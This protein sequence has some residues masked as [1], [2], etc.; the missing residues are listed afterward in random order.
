MF[1]PVGSL[2]PGVY[3]R[4]RVFAAAAIAAVL[5]VVMTVIAVVDPGRGSVANSAA[6]HSV[7]STGAPQTH[8]SSA[9]TGSPTGSS[10]ASP[11]TTTSTA[12]I[13]SGASPT[14]IPPGCV[15][16]QLTITAAT[17]APT[18]QV[19]KEPTLILEVTN[20]GPAQCTQDLADSQI[21][22]RVYNGAARVWGS[23]DCKIEPGTDVKTL[24]VATTV[25][26]QVVWSG[27]SSQPKCAG[28][29]QR[30]GAGT[31]TVYA[32]LSGV[33]GVPAKFTMTGA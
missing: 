12:V 31:Y 9:P 23:H 25:G 29:R 27:L 3:W 20:N 15:G 17:G 6:V 22:L 14:G 13:T 26:V 16:A 18:Y 10:S 8:P 1:H 5:L 4:R 2:P 33:Q 28:T 11:S 21:E 7:A 19:G 32:Y 24:A 30:V